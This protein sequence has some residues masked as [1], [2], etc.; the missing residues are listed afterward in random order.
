MIDFKLAFEFCA[1]LHQRLVAAISD[2]DAVRMRVGQLAPLAP[3]FRETLFCKGCFLPVFDQWANEFLQNR[4]GAS[5]Q[6]VYSALRCEGFPDLERYY[7]KTGLQTYFSGTPVTKAKQR[8]GKNG[9]S[10]GG[11]AC[12]DFA[13]R[14]SASNQA[15]RL[16]GEAKYAVDAKSRSALIKEVH[17]DLLYYV[18]IESDPLTDWAHDFGYGIGYSAGGEGRRA[19]ELIEDYWDSE[20]ILLS[21]FWARGGPE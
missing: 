16:V 20:R 4:Y 8:T 15:L 11:A 9:R 7:P 18:K 19:S 6:I 5:S 3:T 14:F 17:N 12:P 21:V 10:P 13:L 1:G 2:V